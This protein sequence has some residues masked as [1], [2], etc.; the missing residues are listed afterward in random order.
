MMHR[1]REMAQ[2]G[3]LSEKQIEKLHRVKEFR[4]NL[5]HGAKSQTEF[6]LKEALA[7]LKSIHASL[8]ANL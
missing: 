4:N 1:I 5:V 6:E 2:N 8:E 3:E 7:D